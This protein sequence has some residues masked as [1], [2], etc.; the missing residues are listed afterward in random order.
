[1][2]YK[3]WTLDD[4][5]WDRIEWNKIDPELTRIIKSAAMVEFNSADYVAYL[6]H[7]FPD[8]P[9]FVAAARAWGD[10]ERQHGRALSNWAR[11]VEPEFDFDKRFEDFRR[12]FRLEIDVDESIRGSRSG[13]LVARCMVEVGTS[14][15]YS[16]LADSTDEPVIE[17]ICRKIAA[18]E[19]RHYKMFYDHLKRYLDLE[20]MNK[21]KRFR[22]A[23]GRILEIS[24]DELSYAY[25]AAN[26]NGEPYDRKAANDAYMV[27]AYRHYRQ[28]HVDRGMAMIFKAVGLR[29]N[30]TLC[31][32]ASQA[33]LWYLQRRQ[34]SL[35]RRTA[36]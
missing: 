23:M 1:M 35:E 13:E 5:P 17:T 6:E 26:N 4:I 24:N 14:S 3:H 21:L 25:Y 18:D 11:L 22:V 29:P 19:L 8:D 10:E 34:R 20:G 16:A 32:A 9:D 15:Y 7:V 2:G 33:A 31:S 28:P 36:A 12:G 27:R 30:G